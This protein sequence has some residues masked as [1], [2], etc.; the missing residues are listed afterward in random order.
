MSTYLKAHWILLFFV[1]D[2]SQAEIFGPAAAPEVLWHQSY[3]PKQE[4]K[5]QRRQTK[6]QDYL[7]VKQIEREYLLMTSHFRD[8]IYNPIHSFDQLWTSVVIASFV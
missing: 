6:T 3:L 2:T 8:K 5:F 7:R 4:V 1:P